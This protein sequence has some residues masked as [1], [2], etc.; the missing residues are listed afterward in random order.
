MTE[1]GDKEITTRIMQAKSQWGV[2]WN[3]V[4]YGAFS[5]CT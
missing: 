3:C 4:E 2:E 1:T 5:L